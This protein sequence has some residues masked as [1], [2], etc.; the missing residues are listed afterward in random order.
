MGSEVNAFD[1]QETRP[2]ANDP[3]IKAMTDLVDV[4][5]WRMVHSAEKIL[6]GNQATIMA[7]SLTKFYIGD[8]LRTG[9]LR[10]ES[11]SRLQRLFDLI[12]TYT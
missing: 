3:E 11:G 12:K 9:S 10:T 1:S 6:K 8:L 5:Q 4:Y 2:Y 7:D